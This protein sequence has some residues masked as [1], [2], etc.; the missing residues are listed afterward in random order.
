MLSNSRE[1]FR[2]VVIFFPLKTL[3]VENAVKGE[4]YCPHGNGERFH[5]PL[6]IDLQLGGEGRLNARKSR[7]QIVDLYVDAIVFSRR[8]AVLVVKLGH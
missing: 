5:A 6:W 3:K 1:A 8:G 2:R 4:V 7:R